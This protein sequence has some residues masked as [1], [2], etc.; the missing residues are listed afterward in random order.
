V[1]EG[2]LL[3]RARASW[4]WPSLFTFS[5]F[6]VLIK[7]KIRSPVLQPCCSQ[8]QV[9]TTESNSFL[10][11]KVFFLLSSNKTRQ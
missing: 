1:P 3:F 7:N 4:M 11:W 5:S 6:R 2:V 10:S 9:N 8:E